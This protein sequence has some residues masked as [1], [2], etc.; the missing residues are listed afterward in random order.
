[1]QI[2][3]AVRH[4]HLS[5]ASQEKLK[6]KVEKLGRFFDRLMAI[7]VVVDLKDEDNPEVEIIVSAEHKHDF[8]SQANADKLFSAVDSAVQKLEQQLKK[9]KEKLQ[10]RNRNSDSRRQEVLPDELPAPTEE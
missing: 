5:E 8:M 6:Q 7:E 4:G 9:Y 10:Q 3:I 1:M 2:S